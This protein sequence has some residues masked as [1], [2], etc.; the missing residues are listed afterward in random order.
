MPSILAAALGNSGN[1]DGDMSVLNKVYEFAWPGE[2]LKTGNG[3]DWKDALSEDE[4]NELYQRRIQQNDWR[5]DDDPKIARLE[6]AR[7]AFNPRKVHD[8]IKAVRARR[9]TRK[10]QMDDLLREDADDMNE[11]RG[12]CAE[13]ARETE[14]LDVYSMISIEGVVSDTPPALPTEEER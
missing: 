6:P 10:M 11:L 2:N 9:A 13:W 12:L 8:S 7:P 3:P 5:L 14:Q 4:R 1:G